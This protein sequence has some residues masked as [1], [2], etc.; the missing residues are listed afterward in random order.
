MEKKRKIALDDGH[1]IDTAGKRSPAFADGSILKENECNRR[2]AHELGE[3]LTRCG[4]EVIQ[5]APEE[6]DTPLKTRVMRANEAHADAYIS[7]HANAYGTGWNEANGVESWIYEKVM[8]QSQSYL[9]AKAVHE[10]LVA[11]S[12]RRDRGIK[13]SGELYVLR[14]TEMHAVLVECGF[15]TNAEEAALL[16]AEDY[17][18]RLAEGICKGVCGFYGMAYIPPKADGRLHSLAEIPRWGQPLIAEMIAL[19]CFGE[20]DGLDLSMDML[21]TMILME[22]LQKRRESE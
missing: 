3:A 1:G 18:R 17:C 7:I 8:G 22:R 19:R 10:A 9:F 20:E 4:F 21:R 13:R 14:A 11:A 6:T 15:M 2:I 5:V 12:G 16:R